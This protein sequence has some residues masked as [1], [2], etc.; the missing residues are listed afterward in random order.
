[1][2]DPEPKTLSLPI[3]TRIFAPGEPCA[4][5][6]IVRSG[7]VRVELLSRSGRPIVLYRFGAGENCIL[8]LFCLMSR[9]EHC[10]EAYVE[11]DA[12]IDLI[13]PATF[14]Q[15]LRDDAAFREQAFSS[16]GSRLGELMVRIDEL[17]SVSIGSRLAERL[18]LLSDDEHRIEAKHQELAADIGSSREVVS[19]KLAE[20]ERASLISRTRGAIT[21]TNREALRALAST[22]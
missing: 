21:L 9:S 15:R 8:S 19:R 12:V 10:A 2:D 20:W 14:H 3:G 4:G 6:P 7:R 17:M 11:A 18:L 22:T 16:I 1:M 5:L 13:P